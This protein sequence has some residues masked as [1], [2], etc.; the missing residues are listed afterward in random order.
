MGD[1]ILF[2]RVAGIDDWKRII[3][4]YNQSVLE[5]GKTADTE[6]QSI[7]SKSV[8]LN[9]HLDEKY[10]ILLAEIDGHVIGSGIHC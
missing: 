5:T 9:E 4:I 3:E 10:P 1:T 6:L 2:T 8:W 7:E